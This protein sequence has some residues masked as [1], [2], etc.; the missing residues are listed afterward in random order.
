ME[1]SGVLSSCETFA[2]N[3]RR[4]SYFIPSLLV[5]GTL[6]TLLLAPAWLLQAPGFAARMARTLSGFGGCVLALYLALAFLAAQK[7]RKPLSWL[8]TWLGIVSTHYVYGV[9]FLRGF[10]SRTLT[11]EVRAFD[12]QGTRP[13]AS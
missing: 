1:V 3:S 8:L 11:R 2:E 4:L 7:P 5:L 6:G 12:H 13:P 9:A 10:F